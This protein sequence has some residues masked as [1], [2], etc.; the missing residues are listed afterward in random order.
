MKRAWDV[1]PAGGLAA[2]G[3]TIAQKR[4]PVGEEV[5]A[6]FLRHRSWAGQYVK[7]EGN[8]IYFDLAGANRHFLLVS[9]LKRDNIETCDLC[10]YDSEELLH[11]CRRYGTAAGHHGL[12]AA[13]EE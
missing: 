6:S 9:G 1:D 13:L 4:Y 2:I 5:P 11:P 8:T 3:P 12:V 7:V 10:T